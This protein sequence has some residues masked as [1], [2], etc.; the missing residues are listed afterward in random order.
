MAMNKKEKALLEEALTNASL[1]RTC[2]VPP[3]VYPPLYSCELS[4]GFAVIGINSDYARVEIGCS[5]SH[6]N[7]IGRQD[8]TQSQGSINLYSTK[9]LA[10]KSLRYEVENSCAKK[11]RKI[12][13]M[14]EEEIERMK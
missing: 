13:I 11:L 14:I 10:L 9:I 8:K 1:Y 3:D 6:S 5:S 4:K 12:D 7:A 2:Y